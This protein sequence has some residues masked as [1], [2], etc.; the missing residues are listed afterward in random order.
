MGIHLTATLTPGYLLLLATQLARASHV[1]LCI[2]VE[3]TEAV[4]DIAM[5][6]AM[7]I[8][9]ASRCRNLRLHIHRFHA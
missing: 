8:P 4:A 7:L 1:E 6:I 2:S 3:V 5:L 9:C